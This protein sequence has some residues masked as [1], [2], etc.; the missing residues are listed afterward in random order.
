MSETQKYFT[1][2]ESCKGKY[3]NFKVGIL[4]VEGIEPVQ[5]DAIIQTMKADLVASIQTQYPH[6]TREDLNKVPIIT[7]YNTYYKQFEKTYHV[8]AQM[9]SIIAG[10]P[11]S[12]FSALLDAMFMAELKNIMLTAGHDLD[13]VKLPVT[14]AIAN[15]SE[16][17][18][19]INGKDKNPPQGDLYIKDGQGI[20]SSIINGPDSRT[21]M[22]LGTKNALFAVYV[23]AEASV[24]NVRKHL[25]D[26]QNAIT[27]FS[28][29][30]QTKLLEVFVI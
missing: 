24:E 4:V 13:T 19:S 7:A 18:V 25:E 29:N 30:A 5:S 8:R 28:K 11:M 15:G 26:I 10:K 27:V 22:T 21:K 23:P 12:N 9:E 3:P 20:I 6:F 17:Y 1:I 2:D 14:L 16:S